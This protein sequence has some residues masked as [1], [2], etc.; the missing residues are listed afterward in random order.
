MSQ[1]D[2]K[3]ISVDLIYGLAGDSPEKFKDSVIRLLENGATS[4]IFYCLQ[5]TRLYLKNYFDDDLDVYQEYLE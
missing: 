2:F 4:I 3:E 1:Y 5:P